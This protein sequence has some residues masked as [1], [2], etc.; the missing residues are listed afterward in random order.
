M[1]LSEIQWLRMF[2]DN[3]RYLLDEYHMTQKDLA[4]MTGLSEG[5]I[6]KYINRTQ[7]PTVRAIINISYALDESVDDLVDFGERI[8]G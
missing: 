5:T 7:M 8:E 4:E 1:A 2:G 6:S 3:L